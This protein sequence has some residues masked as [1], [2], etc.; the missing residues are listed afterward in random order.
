[1]ADIQNIPPPPSGTAIPMPPSGSIVAMS[2]SEIPAPP[3][4]S[5]VAVQRPVANIPPPPSG[6]AVPVETPDAVQQALATVPRPQVDMQQDGNHM[7]ADPNDVGADVRLG[8]IVPQAAVPA[9]AWLQKNINDPLDKMAAA[10]AGAGKALGRATLGVGSDKDIAALPG[11]ETALG[12]TGAVGSVA[13]GTLADPRNWPFLASGSARPLLQ[14]AISGGFGVTMGKQAIGVAQDL[15]DNWDKYTPEQRAEK[16]TQGGLTALMSAGALTHAVSGGEGPATA[17]PE[18]VSPVAQPIAADA[19]AV[20]P[21]PG[22]QNL[23]AGADEGAVTLKQIGMSM[24]GG[25]KPSVMDRI[26]DA[27]APDAIKEKVADAVSGATDAATQG[28]DRVQA[29]GSA[30]WDAYKEPEQWT[31][32][33]DA[34]GKWDYALQRSSNEAMQFAKDIK[35]GVPDELV[36]EG[37]VNYIQAG[38]DDALLKQRAEAST[39]DLAKGYEAARNLTSTQRIQAENISAWFNQKLQD[40]KDSGMLSAGVENYVNQIWDRPNPV[41]QKLQAD[42]DYGTLRT[43]PS[44]LKQ[45]V[46]DSYFDGEQAGFKPKNKDIGYLV[47][48]YDEAFNNATAGRAFIKSMLDGKGKDG[49]PLLVANADR[50]TAIRTPEGDVTN[51]IAPKFVGEKYADY[52]EVAHPALRKWTWIGKDSDGKPIFQ[53]GDLW[54]HPEV[55]AELENNLSNSWFQQN[56]ATRWVMDK[57]QKIKGSMLGYSLFHQ[58]QEGVHAIGHAVNPFDVGKVLDFDAPDQKTLI[59]H[60]LQVSNVHAQSEFMDGNNDAYAYRVPV[61]GRAAQRYADYLFKD[62][63]P[64]LKVKTALDILDRNRERYASKYTPDQIAELS[65]KQANAA[66]G[67]LNYRQ[68]G[69]NKT[70]Q[71]AFR[72]IGLAP[73][74]LEARGRFVAQALRPE[75]AEQRMAL[76]RLTAVLYGA[77]RVTNMALNNG[78]PR[79]DKPFSVTYKGKDYFLRSIPGDIAHLVSDPRSFFYTRLNPT[80]T[81]P[82]IEELTGRDEFGRQRTTSQHFW[83]TLKGWSPIA[84]QKWIKNPQDFSPLDSVLTGLGVAS[85]KATPS[86]KVLRQQFTSGTLPAERLKQMQTNGDLSAAQ[87]QKITAPVRKTRAAPATK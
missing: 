13:G 51:L 49:R 70:V 40:A 31:D 18:E 27:I 60:G 73:D 25:P 2:S 63:I 59:E 66:Y 78:N 67:E 75:G 39:G 76:L 83:D 65:A 57:S 1:M 42:I 38:G 74:F 56:P 55:K 43:N 33:K 7:V 11:G 35:A 34:R 82:L 36:R 54:A 84:V 44:L 21:G 72:L 8:N 17:N 22:A 77:A 87:V 80:T 15:H 4:G 6:S 37:M 16:I 79:I 47:T 53:N 71:D 68:M 24:R 23:G 10:G 26:N 81:K 29:V 48:A 52:G 64:N 3:S 86:D 5:I 62:Y 58:V 46:F 14:S 28:L 9:L 45:R 12:V 69:R 20:T 32:F 19:D 50:A 41:S 30:L 85:S 61:I